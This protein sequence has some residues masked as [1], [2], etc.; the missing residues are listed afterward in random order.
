MLFH[1]IWRSKSL[2][3]QKQEQ[4][5]PNFEKKTF[6]KYIKHLG[7]GDLWPILTPIATVFLNQIPKNKKVAQRS[8]LLAPFC[9]KRKKTPKFS[10][11][12][13]RS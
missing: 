5:F 8:N 11:G 10:Y 1:I 6:L 12:A 7:N 2:K 4:G 3:Y 9:T 13:R